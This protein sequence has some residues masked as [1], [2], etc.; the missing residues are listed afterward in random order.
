M[1][2]KV[3]NV[4]INHMKRAHGARHIDGRLPARTFVSREATNNIYVII[5]CESRVNCDQQTKD[6]SRR[7]H[8]V[9][10]PRLGN[11]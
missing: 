11:S 4:E 7:V 3:G 10:L 8:D 6:E 5:A 9:F 2:H 1:H